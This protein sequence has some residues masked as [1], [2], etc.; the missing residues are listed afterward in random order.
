MGENRFLWTP[1]PFP[2]RLDPRGHWTPRCTIFFLSSCLPLLSLTSFSLRCG[3][4]EID[5]ISCLQRCIK[6]DGHMFACFS[7]PYLKLAYSLCTLWSNA[8]VQMCI[9]PCMCLSVPETELYM[10]AGNF[11]VCVCEHTQDVLC[12]CVCFLLA[13]KCLR[14]GRAC[15][16]A[17]L[18]IC[19]WE[20]AAQ[21]LAECVCLRWARIVPPPKREGG[22]KSGLSQPS[23][24]AWSC[25]SYFCVCV[26]CLSRGPVEGTIVDILKA[27]SYVEPALRR[28]RGRVGGERC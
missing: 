3:Q 27:R 10:R 22:R 14:G 11:Q 6:D 12:V 18:Q 25:R 28:Q 19:Q 21:G 4:E 24:S 1:A 17:L 9:Y 23:L 15:V 7:I 26:L 2:V 8:C 13:V 20:G 16:R 5:C